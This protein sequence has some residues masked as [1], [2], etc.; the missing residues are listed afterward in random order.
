MIPQKSRL[1]RDGFRARGYRIFSTPYFSLKVKKNSLP[2]NRI[3]VIVGKSVDKRATQRNFWERQAKTQLLLAPTLASDAPLG[4]KD[5]ALMIFPKVRAL[6]K[7]DFIKE[8]QKTI[9]VAM[10]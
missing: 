4:G 7:A 2:T 8:L 9:K 10:Q 5:L 3:G 6:T 1:P